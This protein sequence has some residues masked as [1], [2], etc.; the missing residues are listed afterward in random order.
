MNESIT[1]T[2][3][4]FSPAASLAALGVKLSQRGSLWP[5]PYRGTDSA[6]DRQT[7]ASGQAL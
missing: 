1:P 7:Y 3:S 2:M 5:D 4:H 6:E